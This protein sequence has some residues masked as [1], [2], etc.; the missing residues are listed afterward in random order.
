M[1]S[2]NRNHET[3]NQLR[4]MFEQDFELYG[5]LQKEMTI[6]TKM[7]SPAAVDTEFESVILRSWTLDELNE[8]RSS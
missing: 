7:A 4:R 6:V 8:L 2:S 5:T 1:S 3:N